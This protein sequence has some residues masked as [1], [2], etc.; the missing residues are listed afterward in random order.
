M[1][2]PT[3][4]FVATAAAML[5][6]GA[7]VRFADSTSL[8][9][10][11]LDPAEIDRLV[12]PRTKA[13]V[14]VHYGG[15]PADMDAIRAAADRH[16][17][18]VI[19]DAAHALGSELDGEPCGPFGDAGCF[20]FFP[21][22]NMTTGEGGMIV[23]PRRGRCGARAPPSLARDDDADVGSSSRARDRLRRRR[24]R[25]QLPDR[26]DPRGARE[27]SD[28]AHRRAQRGTLEAR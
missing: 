2:C 18:L 24:P 15:F 10:F 17:L 28:L 25:L 13:V 8:D 19:E 14:V 5:H 11:S 22:K 26:R 27:R 23:V 16:G 7:T 21:N 3:L 1:I 20:S 4:T 9:D 12:T 6:T